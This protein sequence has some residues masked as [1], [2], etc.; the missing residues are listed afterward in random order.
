MSLLIK[1]LEKAEQGK[2]EDA[3]APAGRELMLEQLDAGF[4]SVPHSRPEN[5]PPKQVAQQQASAVFS[6]KQYPGWSMQSLVLGVVVIGILAIFIG[7][8]AYAYL[9]KSQVPDVIAMQPASPVSV[10]RDSE[11]IAEPAVVEPEVAQGLIDASSAGVPDAVPAARSSPPEAFGAPVTPLPEE[12]AVKV[13][14]NRVDNGVN[15]NLLAAYT[16]LS[17]GDDN[18][19][20]QE[21]RKVL[22]SDIRNV[23]ALLGMAAVANRQARYT[24]AAGWYGKVLEIE[25]RNTIAQAALLSLNNQQDTVASESRI[26][27]LLAQQPES[28]YL[29]AALGNLYANGGAWP[30]AQ[31]AYFEA[32]RLDTRNA[33]YA[34]NLAVSLD[35]LGKASLALEY[36]KK[37][38]DLLAG[39]MT[40]IDKAQ[41]DFR[42]SQL[43]QH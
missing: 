5:P 29:Y 10:T 20:L 14:R 39:N 23:D 11:L 37:A 27:N 34:F 31:Q 17:A 18:L 2:A 28:A 7:V 1:A 42:I 26:K 38:R 24:D 8:A 19:A 22:Q 25:P 15:P 33:D 36:Y 35:H 6:A 21:Y 9:G 43:E 41:L 40:D 12:S 16:A 32:F 3:N 4:S 30:A 13:T